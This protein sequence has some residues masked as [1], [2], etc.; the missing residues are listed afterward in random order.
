MVTQAYASENPEEHLGRDV[1]LNPDADIVINRNQDLTGIR[2]YDN[3]VQA[4]INRLKTAMGELEL[5]LNYG[6][7]LHEL[8]GTNPNDLTLSIAKMHV[9][10][11]LLQEPRISE[12][13]SIKPSFR[14]NSNNQVIDIDLV[15][16]P[17]KELD[18]LNLVYSLF[19]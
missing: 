18:T 2:Y 12:I 1:Y 6:S 8:I 3:L 16:T 4:I 19:I 15:V 14:A 5:H 9:R 7:R 13:N 10:E 11:A 17:I